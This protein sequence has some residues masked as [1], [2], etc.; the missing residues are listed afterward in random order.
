MI[1]RK[2]DWQ[3]VRAYATCSFYPFKSFPGFGFRPFR[4]Q[5][6]RNNII[7]SVYNKR[8]RWADEYTP[9]VTGGAR[10]SRDR[11][12]RKPVDCYYIIAEC[13]VRAQVLA[14]NCCTIDRRPYQV[15]GSR[16][17]GRSDRNRPRKTRCVRKKHAPRQQNRVGHCA[18][19]RECARAGL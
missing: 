13:L 1:F 14:R 18:G 15:P 12:G 6:S 4:R 9:L 5:N 19:A 17:D 7:I 3:W 2:I 8:V 11:R 16:S 10:F